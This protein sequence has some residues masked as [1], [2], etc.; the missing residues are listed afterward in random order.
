MNFFKRLADCV[1]YE[2]DDRPFF[3]K[4]KFDGLVK[5]VHFYQNIIFIKKEIS[6]KFYHPNKYPKTLLFLIKKFFS[7]FFD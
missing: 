7:K 2:H 1:N 4:S 3:K 6:K 5:F